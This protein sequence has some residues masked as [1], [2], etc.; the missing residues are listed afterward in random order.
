[1]A[2]HKKKLSRSHLKL[3]ALEARQLLA[4]VTGGGTE[5]GSDIHHPNGNTYDQVLMTG[6]SVTVTADAGQ[7][8]RVSF[9]DLQ[10]DIVQ[11]EF[12]GAGD[13]TISLD[14]FVGPAEA[15]NYVQPGVK[16]VQGLATFTITGENASTNF[17]VFSVGSGNAVVQS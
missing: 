9:L 1:M 8:T 7:I 17:S 12:S 2:K 11:A 10:G 4:G 3:E 6:S 16:Y 15:A 13:L 14:K 5:V